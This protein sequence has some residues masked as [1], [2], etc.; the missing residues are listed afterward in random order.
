MDSKPDISSENYA[1]VAPPPYSE[2][3][4]SPTTASISP[5][6]SEIQS[7]LSSLIPILTSNSQTSPAAPCPPS[8]QELQTKDA[9]ILH[10]IVPEITAY[11]TSFARA[12]AR[13]GTLVFLPSSAIA[14]DETAVLTTFD[15]H[16][17]EDFDQVVRV[18]ENEKGRPT[19]L[20]GSLWW[21]DEKMAKRLAEAL[22]SQ[23]KPRKE[24]VV[25]PPPRNVVPQVETNQGSFWRKLSGGN[26]SAMMEEERS[27]SVAPRVPVMEEEEEPGKPVQMA[28]TAEETL[29][30][31]EN[32]FGIYGTMTGWCIVLRM[33]VDRAGTGATTG[34]T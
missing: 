27:R 13:S 2:G 20:P 25:A 24:K 10:H 34:K 14:E 17:K 22:T 6:A 31:T 29:F 16:A 15:H 28:F 32:G 19:G 23:R 1:D 18:K 3:P 30:R 11:L 8:A 7:H 33:K 26:R 9:Y 12:E 4:F 5:F 21:K